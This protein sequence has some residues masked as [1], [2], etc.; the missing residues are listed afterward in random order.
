MSSTSARPLHSTDRLG[1]FVPR[2][3][4][5][6]VQC[7]AFAV[8]GPTSWNGLPHLLRAKI[9]SGISATS[10]RSLK[11][12]ISFPFGA[13]ALKAP[14]TSQYCERRSINVL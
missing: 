8:T 6:L 3:R 7:R 13:A 5:A 2:V 4:T 11:T 1:L 9:M 12:F 10:C 14:L